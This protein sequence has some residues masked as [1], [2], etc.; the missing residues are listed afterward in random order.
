MHQ[1]TRRP[2][3]PF[4]G[5]YALG[6]CQDS[7]SAIERKMTGDVTLFPNTADVSLFD[8]AR[9]AEVNALITA[10]PKDRTGAKPS[11][12]RVFGSLPTTDFDKITVP[13]LREDLRAT[14]DAWQ[15]GKLE[16][17]HGALF[18]VAVAGAGTVIAAGLMVAFMWRRKRMEY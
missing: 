18:Y 4:G 7:V 16:H 10:I 14:H 13:G 1:H 3:L 15:N 11:P 12:E 6:V 9:D 8:D 5:Y 17:T 2:D